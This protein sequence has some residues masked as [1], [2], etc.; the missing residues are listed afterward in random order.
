MRYLVCIL[1]KKI[2]GECPSTVPP[3]KNGRIRIL[4]LT[5]NDH[6]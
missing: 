2:L 3:T 6:L 4:E 1:F 5:T